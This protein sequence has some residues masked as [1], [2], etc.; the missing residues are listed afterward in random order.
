MANWFPD[1]VAPNLI[2]LAGFLFILSGVVIIAYYDVVSKQSQPPSTAFLYMALAIFLYIQLDAIDGKQARRLNQSTPLG[3][4]FDHGCD[5]ITLACCLF[6]A[7]VN[8]GVGDDTY[9]CCLCFVLGSSLFYFAL[10]TQYFTG[11]L[12]TS[13]EYVGVTEFELFF[14]LMNIFTAIFG[15]G[16]WHVQLFG[17]LM[18]M[19]IILDFSKRDN[20]YRCIHIRCVRKELAKQD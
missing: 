15:T 13:T 18:R 4:L 12:M 17:R 10:F 20:A 11:F 14:V 5:C 2:T 6:I 16:V 1:W 19:E 9:N 7:T 3:Q 8:C